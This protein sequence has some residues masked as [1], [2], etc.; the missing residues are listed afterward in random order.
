MKL[1]V[2]G[3][4]GKRG[5]SG[6]PGGASGGAGGDRG[7]GGG[8]GGG[9]GRAG[10]GA[11]RGPRARC[12]RG[13]GWRGCSMR[14]ARSSRSGATAAHGMYHGD[15]PC[16]RAD[17]RGRAGRRAG[18]D[19][20]GERRHREG[21]HLLSDDGEEA[22]ARAG[23]RGGERAALRLS[24][25]FGRGEPAEPGRGLSRPGAFRADLLQPGADVGAG[26]RA[27]RGGHG[28]VHGGRGLCAG[29]VGRDGDRARAGDDLSRRAAAGEGGDRRGGDGGGSGRR[30]RA[31]PALGGGGLSRRGRR[32][33]AGAGAGGGEG[34][35]PGEAGDGGDA[36]PGG[37]GL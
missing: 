19:G 25:G 9:R 15:A 6:E 33:C 28:V 4:D 34:A 27:D 14:G 29:D 30:G 8:G 22:P 26:D 17:R 37:A 24:G 20:G 18:G 35:E 7:G 23:D 12:C 32:A 13:S 31:Y 16:G 2:G 11:A 3:G 10:G 1:A 21:R 36:G 5:L